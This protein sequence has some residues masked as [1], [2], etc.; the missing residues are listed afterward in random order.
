MGR[1]ATI[2]FR[3]LQAVRLQS[4]D[5]ASAVVTQFGAHLVSWN[6]AGGEERIFLSDRS[7]FDGTSPIRGGVPIVFPQFATCGPLPHHGLVRQ[8]AWH[9]A[10]AGTDAS[11][12]RAAF[13][14]QD[15]DE[16]RRLWPHAFAC[17]MNVSIGADTLD[18]QLR[19]DNRG[20]MPFEFHAALHTY[21]RVIDI[22]AVR[23][24]GLQGTRY[25]NRAGRDAE[26]IDEGQTL[27]IRGEVDRLYV[28]APRC[29]LLR[30]PDRLMLIRSC[31]LPDA[32]VWNPGRE[33]CAAIADLAPDGY[34]HFL[35]VEA[36]SA[37]RWQTL[38]PGAHWIGRQEMQAAPAGDALI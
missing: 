6:P 34:R 20:S 11:A 38:A 24:E 15:D 32:V 18:L 3:G 16:T 14:L 27:A 33:R 28:D 9:L 21:L 17:T 26:G 8:R 22:E 4:D 23:V 5:G 25:R 19:I 12:A 2:D 13:R 29:L 37:A 1:C 30:E 31:V 36:A 10:D 35:C 7:A